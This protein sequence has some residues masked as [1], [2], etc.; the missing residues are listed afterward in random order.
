VALR[1]SFLEDLAA[2][3]QEKYHHRLHALTLVFPTWRAG[4][5]F[6]RCL[7][8]HLSQPTWAPKVLSIEALMQQLSPLR[9][10]QP[11]LLT[12]ILYQTFQA[13]NPQEESFEQFYFW[14]SLLLQDLDVIDKY[15]VSTAHLFTDLSRYKELGLSYDHLTEAQRTAIQSFWKNFQQQL[16]THQQDFLRLWKLLPQVYQHFKQRLQAQGIGYQGLCY[17]AAYEALV[18]GTA[19]VQ[20]DQLV[21]VGFNALT[22]V[23]EKILAWCQENLP[24]EFYWDVDAYYMEDTQQ[25]A[26]TYLRIYQQRPHFQASFVQPFPKRLAQGTQEIHLTAVASEVGQAQVMGAQLRA[27]MEAQGAD[28]VPSRTVIVVANEALLLPVLHALPLDVS[29]VST[30]L[31]YPLKD[32]ATYRLLEHMLA[33][34]AATAQEQFPS[35]YWAV[36]HVLAVLN[37]P[38]V[39]GWNA[40]LVQAT[41]NRIQ[42]TKSSYVAQEVLVQENALYETIF[43]VLRPQDHLLRYLMEGLQCIEAYAQEEA[44]S[45]RP[46]EK[47]ALHQLLQQLSNFQEVFSTS[48]TKSEA[49]LQLLRQLLQPVRIS[50]GSQSLDG[51][52]ILDVLATRN[53]DFDHVF[54]VGMNEGHFPIQASPASFIP[55]NLRKGYGLPTADQHQAALYAYHFYHLLQRARQVYISYSTQASAGSQGEMSRYIWQLLYESKL[56]LTKQVVAQPIYLATAHPI[57]IPKKDAVMQQL[58]KYLLQSDGKAQPLT[59]SSLNTYLDCSLRFYFQYLAQ[60]KAPSPPQQATHAMVF[61]NLLHEVM[62]RLYTPLMNKKQ[63]QPLQSQDLAALQKKVA[64]VVKD[65]FASTL[66]SGQPQ[67]AGLQGDAVI[68]QAVM[69]KLATRI[70]VLDQA[71]APFVLI[72]LEMGRQVSLHL[73]FELNLVTRVRLQGIIDRVDWKAGVFRVLDYKTGLDEKNIKSVAGLFDRV[74]T[75]RN[76]AAFQTLFYAWLFQQQRLPGVAATALASGHPTSPPEEVKI[77]P[78]LLN[79]RQLFDDHFDPRFFIQ[80]PDSRTYL[81]IEN[82]TAYQ[83]EWEQGLRQTLTELLDPAVPFV[84]T[85]DAARCVSCPYKGICQRH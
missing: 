85:A 16:S 43:K 39:M 68:A 65:T 44:P 61:G 28:F 2:E 48:S 18:Q 54:I 49:L 59:P 21:F 71:H 41:I 25:E 83:D 14:G 45:L 36:H 51:I 23:E 11:L 24:T 19:Q 78:G 20:H 55:Y 47:V 4:E 82:I 69:T 22:P 10:A 7:A 13:L 34:Q 1:S 57:I 76:K 62:E 66:H 30:H 50:L 75:R 58:R 31:G 9:Q 27:L 37:H 84:Q 17:R 3:L 5:V 53:L 74:T 33:L 52:Q 77:M 8:T 29:P 32:T 79:T 35:G 42:A 15:L 81:P 40:V 63:G 6:K 73:D 70:L 60:L 72:G 56:R 12:H 64:F 67:L 46:L 80:K 26:G 38:H